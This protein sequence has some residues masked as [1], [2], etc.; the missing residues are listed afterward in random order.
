MS[1]AADCHAAQTGRTQITLFQESIFGFLHKALDAIVFVIR[2][3]RLNDWNVILKTP[4]R[5]K[6]LSKWLNDPSVTDSGG[7]WRSSNPLRALSL[8]MTINRTTLATPGKL[9]L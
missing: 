5:L 1:L 2:M 6:N 4:Q 7:P 3:N 8:R 9:D